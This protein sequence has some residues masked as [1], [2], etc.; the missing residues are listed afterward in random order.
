[1]TEKVKFEQCPFTADVKNPT[2]RAGFFTDGFLEF[3]SAGVLELGAEHA[4]GD[5]IDSE[6]VKMII[7]PAHHCLYD[8]M[9]FM[10]CRAAGD[11]GPSPNM[12][13]DSL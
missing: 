6:T 9:K 2:H 11:E 5:T 12:R 4:I 13:F 7:L 10:H 3:D 8:F 1:M